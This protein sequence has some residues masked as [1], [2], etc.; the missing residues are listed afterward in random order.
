HHTNDATGIALQK[1][2]KDQLAW[3]LLTEPRANTKEVIVRNVVNDQDV[4]ARGR[5]T[6]EP[7]ATSKALRLLMR[8]R[9]C[10]IMAKELQ[11]PRPSIAIVVVFVAPSTSF[12]FV[13]FEAIKR[14]G[15]S[16]NVASKVSRGAGRD[17]RFLELTTKRVIELDE[18]RS[19]P[20]RSI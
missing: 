10:S 6:N 5:L 7:L 4:L 16:A 8:L 12:V 13:P 15:W 2:H 3:R 9:R 1:R 20:L 18:A 19:N 14:S 17:L 11:H